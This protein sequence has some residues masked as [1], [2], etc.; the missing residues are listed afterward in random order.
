V[1]HFSIRLIPPAPKDPPNTDHLECTPLPGTE[2]AEKYG[3]VHFYVDRKLDLPVRVA[4]VEKE[5]GNEITASFTNPKV[6]QGLAGS[7]LNLPELPGYSITEERLPP[8]QRPSARGK[9]H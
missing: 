1:Q 4:T 3:K 6:N 2:T 9:T 5:G 8:P 7:K